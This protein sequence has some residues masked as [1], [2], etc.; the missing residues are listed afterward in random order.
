MTSFSIIIKHE[1]EEDLQEIFEYYE[2]KKEGLGERFINSFD[3]SLNKLEGNPF[4]T[5]NVSSN[6]RSIVTKIFPYSIYFIVFENSVIIF[7]VLH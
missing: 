3:D 4:S 5:V 6:I 7:A 2:G 1:A